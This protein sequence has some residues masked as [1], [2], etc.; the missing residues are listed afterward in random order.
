M[1]K[2][3]KIL[4]VS[5]CALIF[6]ALFLCFY[7]FPQKIDS[8]GPTVIFTDGHPLSSKVTAIRVTGTRRRPLFYNSSFEGAIVIDG[9]DFTGR[10]DLIRVEFDKSGTGYLV[11]S[12]VEDGKPILKSLGVIRTDADFQKIKVEITNP[13]L[14]TGSEDDR[15]YICAPARTYTEAQGIG[16]EIS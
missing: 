2:N 4:V 12:S 15:V 9:Y 13:E 5:S 1:I 8:T 11:Y 14:T 6:V 10:Y 7:S 16:K 3:K